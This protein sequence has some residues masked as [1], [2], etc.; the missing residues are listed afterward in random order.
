MENQYNQGLDKNKANYVPL[1]PLTFVKRA[2]QVYPTK[3]S[4]VY[5][6]KRYNWKQTYERACQLAAALSQQGVGDG[7]TVSVMGYNTPETYEAHFGIPMTGGVMHAI[8]TRLDAKNIAFMMDH[9]NTKLLLLSL[10]HI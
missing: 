5:G 9:A 10:I 6:S 4:V 1:S 7:D 8:N 2:A 3:T